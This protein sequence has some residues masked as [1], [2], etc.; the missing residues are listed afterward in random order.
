MS[1][2]PTA[3][4]DARIPVRMGDARSAGPRSH[5]LIEADLPANGAAAA[6]HSGCFCCAPRNAL[7]RAL[8]R[9]FLAQM[10]GEVAEFNEVVVIGTSTT[11]ALAAAIAQDVVAAARFRAA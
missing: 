5:I 6:H 10:R 4:R 8:S 11:P 7:A 2:D 1:N 9:L 3:S